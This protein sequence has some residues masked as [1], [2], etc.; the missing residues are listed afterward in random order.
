MYLYVFFSEYSFAFFKFFYNFVQLQ[1]LRLEIEI[2]RRYLILLIS[3]L[4]SKFY[5]L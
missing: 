3:L 5:N 1:I 2:T 4:R